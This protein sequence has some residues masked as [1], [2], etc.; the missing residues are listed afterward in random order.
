[1]CDVLRATT[2]CQVRCSSARNVLSLACRNSIEYLTST[3]CRIIIRRTR[4]A[5]SREVRRTNYSLITRTSLVKKKLA[6]RGF[7][8]AREIIYISTISPFSSCLMTRAN[9]TKSNFFFF[10]LLF[11]PSRIFYLKHFSSLRRREH[12]ARARGYKFQNFT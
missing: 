8:K 2:S 10:F 3:C 7:V 11:L 1:M 9:R 12:R 6:S 5:R 4:F